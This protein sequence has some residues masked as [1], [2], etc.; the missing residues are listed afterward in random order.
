[1]R[2]VCSEIGE[3]LYCHDA[4]HQVYSGW[5]CG[6][7]AVRGMSTSPFF[8]LVFTIVFCIVFEMSLAH[9]CNILLIGTL[10]LLYFS[11]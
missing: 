9:L 8:Y 2:H 10:T 3:W 11:G 6:D 7:A 1:M 5:L 4:V